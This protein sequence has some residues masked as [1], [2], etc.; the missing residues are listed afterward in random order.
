MEQFTIC[1]D[2]FKFL[3]GLFAHKSDGGERFAAVLR[4]P[5]AQPWA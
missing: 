3:H 1:V 5:G 2:G 4:M